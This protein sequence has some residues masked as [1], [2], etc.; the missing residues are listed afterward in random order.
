MAIEITPSHFT[1][2]EQALAE[3]ASDRLFLV[4]VDTR[5]G[6]LSP[7]AHAH[8]YRVDIYLLEG[9]LELY[10]PDTGVTQ[11][12]EAGSKAVVP[13]GIVHLE[14]TPAVFRSAIGLSKDPALILNP[15]GQ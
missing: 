2:R 12:L 6:D 8:D 4:E 9:V 13:A 14:H 10:E 1:T 7:T 11:R 3:I 15:A 5:P